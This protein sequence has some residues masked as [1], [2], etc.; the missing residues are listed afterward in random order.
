MRRRLLPLLLIVALL[1]PAATASAAPVAAN[2]PPVGVLLIGG[3]GSNAG[4]TTEKFAGLTALL[5]ARAGR[6][7]STFTYPYDSCMALS[8]AE[9]QLATVLRAVQALPNLN[10]GRLALVGHSRGGLVAFQTLLDYPDVVPMVSALVAIDTPFLGVSS[11]KALAFDLDPNA[12]T[13]EPAMGELI[14]RRVNA[15]SWA[16]WNAQGV[17]QLMGQGVRVQA[18]GNRSDCVYNLSVCHTFWGS[19]VSDDTWAQGLATGPVQRWYNIAG[20]GVSAS[21]SAV[22]H[23]QRA[24]QDIADFI[25]F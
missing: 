11:G 1:L 4:S 16:A 15:D 24:V 13:C 22:M 23:D 5:D 10:G 21:H 19:F 3:I 6:A 25:G 7:N 17:N 9:A 12:P 18:I 8:D 14:D 2:D 20:Q